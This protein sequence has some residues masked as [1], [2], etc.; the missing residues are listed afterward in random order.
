[1]R[2]MCVLLVVMGAWL[3]GC[4]EGDD[5]APSGAV[6]PA[7]GQAGDPEAEPPDSAP[8]DGSPAGSASPS[9]SA[10][11]TDRNAPAIPP[12]TGDIIDSGSGLRYIDEAVGSGALPTPTQ[13]VTVHYTGWLTDGTQF[14]TSRDGSPA[15]FS[16]AG[17]IEGWTE[18]VGGMQA[19]GKRRL[20]IPGEL[21][22]G[23]GGFPPTI[24]PNATLIFDVELISLGGEPVVQNGRAICTP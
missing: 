19:G 6:S 7:S 9:V 8:E 10:D 15:T 1:M 14:D 22:Y 24:G 5:A 11:E 12:L 16:L 2:L 20:I 23:A 18:G 17:V 4:G 13:C 21:A 3:V